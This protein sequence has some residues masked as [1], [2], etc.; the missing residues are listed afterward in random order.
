MSELYL[1]LHLYKILIYELFDFSKH[2]KNKTKYV[3]AVYSILKKFKSWFQLNVYK[4]CQLQT[5]EEITS[6][7]MFQRQK[8]LK[9][10][11]LKE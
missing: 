8:V 11:V 4:S 9:V 10:F 7:K 3:S 5:K 1:H 6:K 2:F